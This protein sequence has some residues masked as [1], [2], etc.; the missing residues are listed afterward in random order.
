M[1]Q[2]TSDPRL[3]LKS[4]IAS[5]EARLL[6]LS[7]PQREL[8]ENSPVA[9]GDPANHICAT[10]EIRG[11]FSFDLCQEAL[12]AVVERQEVLRTSFLSGDGK[13]AQIVVAKTEANLRCRDV[14]PG[15]D[16]VEVMA[17]VFSEPFD[18]VR[19]PLYR[20]EMLRRAA[21]HHTLA[22]VFHHAIADGWTLGVFVED[23][24]M[25]YILA[26]QQSGR[27]FAPLT[28]LKDRLPGPG[29]TYS[30]WAAADRSRWQPPGPPEEAA[31]WR[32]RLAGSGLLF[33]RPRPKEPMKP[34]C[35][36]VTSL[37]PALVEAA[38]ALAKQAGV[39][40]F[41]VLITAFQ[42][43]LNRWKAT[44]DVVLGV[45]HAN[46]SKPQTRETMG[47]FA[48]V[49]PLRL[50]LEPRHSFLQT[51]RANHEAQIEDFAHAMPFAELAKDL[52]PR[53]ERFC[54][55]IFDVRFALQNHPVPD[56]ELPGISTRLRTISTGTSRFDLACELTEDGPAME[57]VWLYRQ[58]VVDG[59]EIGHLDRLLGVVLEEG[60][61]NAGVPLEVSE[62]AR[63]CL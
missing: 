43:T 13:A 25:A 28:G 4:L 8:W 5:G 38:R 50:R 53:D 63:P 20:V 15:E 1:T 62:I 37:E 58:F 29:M 2:P 59:E 21:D 35:K 42:V 56:I 7:F 40:L 33:G 31:Y 47:Y 48:G 36:R 16:P 41:S 23:F 60:V 18:M 10:I 54:H 30:E 61:R 24:T 3:R 32:S 22:L 52:A 55:Q 17:T 6:P 26:L 39:T 19:G 27:A 34:L 45:P 51:L 11:V 9:P 57:V 12:Q 49:V 44:K 46:R 14:E